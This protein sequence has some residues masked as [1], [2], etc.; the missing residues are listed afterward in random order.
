MAVSI[1]K[2]VGLF[3]LA[4]IIALGVLIEVVEDRYG[5]VI[6]RADRRQCDRCGAG[7]SGG[8]SPRIP[9][10]GDQVM[11]PIT[12]YQI[13]SML[14]GVVLR[15]TATRAAS[16]GKPLGG[17][18]GTTNDYRSAWFM[19]FSP[20]L[21]VGVYIGFDDNRSLGNN[22]TGS[23][24]AVPIFVDFMEQALKDKPALPF[25]APAN[26]KYAMIRGIREAFRP[27]TEPSLST[28]VLGA[29]G[30]PSGPQPYDQVF[31][32][33]VTGAPNAAA[34]V[35]PAAA[36]PPKKKDDLSDLF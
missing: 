4:T 7:F 13:T 31:G 12:A 22:E 33:G 14:E 24:E 15:G 9:R 2:K 25:K 36:P 30:A 29:A 11:D 16:I 6:W 28:E 1:E 17:K 32:N 21:V 10:T 23:Q 34:A 26:A 19:G 20:D 3:F 18:T 8:E 35:A 5:K 27:G